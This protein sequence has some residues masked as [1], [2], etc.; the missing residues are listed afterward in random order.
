MRWRR[1]KWRFSR[2]HQDLRT[3]ETHLIW[4]RGWLKN[5]HNICKKKEFDTQCFIKHFL[6]IFYIKKKWANNTTYGMSVFPLRHFTS[7]IISWHYNAICVLFTC[8]ENTQEMLEIE[9]KNLIVCPQGDGY[10][11]AR[12]LLKIKKSFLSDLSVNKG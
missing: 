2:Q 3:S 1:E 9:Y 5:K 10:S 4:I 6:S 7:H 8:V 12:L 11:S